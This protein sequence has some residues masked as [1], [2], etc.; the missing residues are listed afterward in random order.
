MWALAEDLE[1]APVLDFEDVP[2]P[3]REWMLTW[4]ASP[5]DGCEHVGPGIVLYSL[6]GARR[7][8]CAPCARRARLDLLV[9]RCGRCAASIANDDGA[10]SAIF[11]WGEGFIAALTVCHHCLNEGTTT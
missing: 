2:S 1:R 3:A 9:T 8:M 10:I 4:L 5:R 7:A 6:M 11:S